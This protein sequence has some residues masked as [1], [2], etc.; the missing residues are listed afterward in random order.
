MYRRSRVD[1]LTSEKYQLQKFAAQVITITNIF[2]LPTLSY[3]SN[4]VTFQYTA[5]EIFRRSRMDKIK[6]QSKKSV[7]YSTQ[8]Y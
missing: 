2:L 1:K 4:R 5:D 7:T 6:F 8:Y 3:V